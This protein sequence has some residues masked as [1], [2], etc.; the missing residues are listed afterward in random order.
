MSAS[1]NIQAFIL[2]MFEFHYKFL[3]N[4]LDFRSKYRENLKCNIQKLSGQV[5]LGFVVN[6][7]STTLLFAGMELK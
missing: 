5:M 1:Y 6:S 4:N 2:I 7:S 3:I